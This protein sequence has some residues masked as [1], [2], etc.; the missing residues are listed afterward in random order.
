MLIFFIPYKH[1]NN[2]SIIL[3]TSAFHM[4]RSKYLF[5]KQG[6]NVIPYPVDFKSTNKKFTFLDLVPTVHALSNTSNFIR[7]NIGR[8]YY[9]IIL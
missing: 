5:Q 1:L 7:E 4:H 6:L 8:L 9:K 3:V 2:S